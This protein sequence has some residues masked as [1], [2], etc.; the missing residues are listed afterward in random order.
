MT[1]QHQP[2]GIDISS[3]QGNV[4]YTRMKIKTS[5]V[6]MRAGISWGWE[7][8]KF[9][10]NWNGLAGHN[11]AAYHVV[12]PSQ[13]AIRQADRFLD[14]V[15]RAGADWEHDRLALD[16]ELA[17]GQSRQ[18]IT[19]VVLSM[20]ERLK[21]VTGR[22]PLLYSRAYWV[23]DYMN[24]TDERIKNADWWI[25]NYMARQDPNPTPEHPGP[26]LLPRGIDTWLIHQTSERGIGRDFGASSTYI[27]LNRWNATMDEMNAYFGHGESE[28]PTEPPDEPPS[29]EN[30]LF[31]V[32]I[33]TS[34]G[35]RYKTYARANGELLH[36]SRWLNS[37]DIEPVFEV[38]LNHWYRITDDRWINGKYKQWVKIIDNTEPV[39]AYFG[40][41]YNQRDVRWANVVLGTKSTIGANGCLLTGASMALNALGIESNPLKLN[42]QMKAV[43]GYLDGN[44]FIWEKIQ[45][46]YPTIKFNGHVF[47]PTYAQMRT[48]IESGKLPIIYVDFVNNTPEIEMHWVFGV[49]YDSTDILSADPWTGDIFRLR[50]RYRN[51]IMRFG[52]Y[53]KL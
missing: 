37:G 14:I 43:N 17:Q 18:R 3:H 15:T 23:N 31:M 12:Y 13:D 25:A 33:T 27:D 34:P 19:N 44:L 53:S 49:G 29:E 21:S 50:E 22:Y 45:Q 41:V 26:P 35:Y 42:E 51:H 4:D 16:L 52:S 2:L 32:K 9:R 39:F 46:I 48:S 11:R 40:P 1:N 38:Q 20:M 24:V 7:D 47:N 28:P 8:P 6:I 30:P 10:A 5:Y 36:D